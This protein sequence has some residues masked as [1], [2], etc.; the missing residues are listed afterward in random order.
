M[1]DVIT[2]STLMNVLLYSSYLGGVSFLLLLLLIWKTPVL[3]FA[4][5]I[6]RGR[7]INIISNRSGRARFQCMKETAQGVITSKP[8]GPYLV[9]E[10]SNATEIYSGRP[11]YFSFGEFGA[12]LPLWWISTINKIKFWKKKEGSLVHNLLDIGPDM[13]RVYNHEK[14]RWEKKAPRGENKVFEIKPYETIKLHD[15]ANMFPFN[16]TPA[17]N[18]S[19][20]IHHIALKQK[21][22]NLLS[23]Q[24]FIAVGFGALLILI[25]V[26]I[27]MKL[28]S[29]NDASAETQ[30]GLSIV[31]NLVG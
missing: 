12:T 10:G 1:A 5:A 22:N 18:E 13:G 27:F 24:F 4:I 30:A 9:T 19:R 21:M 6:I 31:P 16:I 28:Y 14:A 25:G 23:A 11:I 26:A 7:A 15:L 20:V 3:Q 17:L 8:T 29:G 2:S